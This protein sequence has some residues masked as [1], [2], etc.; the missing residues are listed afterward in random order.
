MTV[1]ETAPEQTTEAPVTEAKAVP[2]KESLSVLAG[3]LLQS[4]EAKYAEIKAVA[5][6]QAKVGNVGELLSEAIANS[7]DAKVKELRTKRE[8]ASKAILE[9]D[10]AMEEIVKPTLSIPTDEELSEMDTTYKTLAS[11]LNT[12]N[13]VFATEIGKTHPNITLFDYV[14]EL[15]GKRRGA[16][17][18]Q[19]SGTSRPRVKSVEYTTDK[20]GEQGWKKAEKDGKST[21][22]HLSLAI[23]SE[24]GET[25]GAGDF[26]KAWTE[27]LSITDWTDAPEVSK[28]AYSVTDKDDKTHQYWVRVT[29]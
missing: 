11:E 24:T 14:G 20:N 10:K 28:F 18:G 13:T 2:A 17:Q 16:K 4:A 9:M 7:E 5:D 25:H 12:F 21:F 19:G 3:A 29:R 23:K 6:K 8:R 15:P 22:S 26:H 27:S 1:T